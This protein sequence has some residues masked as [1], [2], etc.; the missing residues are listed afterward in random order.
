MSEIQNAEPVC[1]YCG[2]VFDAMPSRRRSCPSC[3]NAVY[4][5]KR[6]TDRTLRLVTEQQANEIE[7]E[8]AKI[9]EDKE[10][11]EFDEWMSTIQTSNSHHEK[12]TAY[13]Q[14]ALYFW[15]KGD[16]FRGQVIECL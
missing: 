11:K 6:P 14:L 12:M 1:P 16:E 7:K 8:W 3:K 4:R 10:L 9:T 15:R 5:K 2:F 13:H